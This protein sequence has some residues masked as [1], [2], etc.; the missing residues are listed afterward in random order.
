M[1]WISTKLLSW[2]YLCGYDKNT[3]TENNLE[4]NGFIWFIIPVYSPLLWASQ[5]TNHIHILEQ[6]GT[7]CIHKSYLRKTHETQE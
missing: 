5:G 3:M 7:K 1:V 4:K 2:L 6:R